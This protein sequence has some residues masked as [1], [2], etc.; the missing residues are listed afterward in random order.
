MEARKYVRSMVTVCLLLSVLPCATRVR[1][2][3][4]PDDVLNQSNWQEAKG[5]MPEAVLRRFELGQ[6]LLQSHRTS[7]RGVALGLAL[8]RGHGKEPEH[9]RN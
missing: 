3:L 8:Q 6:H 2:E 5:M 1:A 9:L 7:Q 4:K